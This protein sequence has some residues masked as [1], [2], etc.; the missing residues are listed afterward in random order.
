MIEIA[1]CLCY[2]SI[3]IVFL[4]FFNENVFSLCHTGYMRKLSRTD[5]GNRA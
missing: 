5:G 1:L 2:V 3:N 4:E